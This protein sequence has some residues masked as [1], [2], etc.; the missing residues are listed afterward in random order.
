VKLDLAAV[1]QRE[2]VAAND[3]EHHRA[4]DEYQ[5]GNDRDDGP[6][7]KQRCEQSFVSITQLLEAA[8]ES[9]RHP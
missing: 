5:D 1:D 4:E 6:P 8:L 3:R 2:K 7:A 9:S